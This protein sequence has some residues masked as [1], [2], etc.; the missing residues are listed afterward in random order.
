M[1]QDNENIRNDSLDLEGTLNSV[2]S[3][4]ESMSRLASMASALASS[5]ILSGLM[6]GTGGE[7][8]P[9]E[10]VP[11]TGVGASQE[12]QTADA[13]TDAGVRGKGLPIGGVS[14]RHAA[15]L[16]AIKP[17]LGQEKQARVD[18]MMKLLKLAEL[19]DTV[20]RGM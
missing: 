2:L 19:A 9:S 17:Y 14:G 13:D 5:G 10:T 8:T 1:A 15:L 16:R 12:V 11:M 18:Q 3:D 6:G 7:G 20:L 4:P